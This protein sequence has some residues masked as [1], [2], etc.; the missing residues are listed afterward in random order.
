[1][2]KLFRIVLALIFVVIAIAA[3]FV[4]G[5]GTSFSGNKRFLYIYEGKNSRDSVLALLNREDYL[6]SPRVFTFV[7]DRLDLWSRLKPGKFEIRNGES[8][9]SIVRKLRNNQQSPVNL[10]INKLRTREDLARMI[11]K[12][13]AT[14][15]AT[16]SAFL[17]SNDSLKR[18]EVDTNTMITLVIPNTYTFFWNTPVR[19]V[20][21]RLADEQ[22]KFWRKNDRV[23]KASN[24]G[25]TTTQVYI[26][27]SIVEEE[28]NRND[29]KG[30]VASVYINRMNA[31]MPLGADP[32][33]K[34]A[35]RDFSIRRIFNK[36][37]AVESPYNT[38]RNTGLP[39]GPICTP[40]PVTIDK[41]LEAPKTS[42]FYF[43][44]KTDGS[45]YHHF[46][47]TFEEH[48]KYAS[49]YHQT[50]DERGNR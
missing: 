14:D 2:K 4:F 26:L 35:L 44:A 20:I 15:S 19:K 32:T 49:E 40:S 1:M 31:G 8:V 47:T 38:Y 25:L 28:T 3:W 43:V 34:F 17:N 21:A 9:I 48:K 50:Q 18:F 23:N 24:A 5:S 13:F 45:G 11:G 29:E 22:E 42:Y 6:S 46:S 7:A 12:Q 37:L 39:P 27:A 41:V 16:A 10:V 30:Q 33:V 36:H